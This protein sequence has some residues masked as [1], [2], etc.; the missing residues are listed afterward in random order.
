MGHWSSIV[1]CPVDKLDPR[2]KWPCWNVW[3]IKLE[4]WHS[5]EC[6]LTSTL[7]FDLLTSNKMVDQ[8]LSCTMHLP[9][10]VMIRLVVFVLECWHTH[11]YTYTH[12]YR[13]DKRPTPATTCHDVNISWQF[14]LSTVSASRQLC[15]WRCIAYYRRLNGNGDT[16]F[17][18]ER[19]NF[20]PYTKSKPRTD[21]NVDVRSWTSHRQTRLPR[22]SVSNYYH[23]HH[24]QQQQ[25]QQHRHHHHLEW[26]G[27]SE[28]LCLSVGE[29]CIFRVLSC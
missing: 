27:V 22:Q 25:K 20:D 5:E 23:Y 6:K 12:T 10:L 2:L 17:R 16:S 13:A 3:Y 26:N 24:R 1:G 21:W 8:D 4:N 28:E 9:S 15:Y 29:V 14:H 7:T 11:T 19:P 18:W